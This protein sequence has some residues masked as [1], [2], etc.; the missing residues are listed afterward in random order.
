MRGTIALDKANSGQVNSKELRN[1]E[2]ASEKVFGEKHKQ[3]KHYE[4]RGLERGTVMEM[5]VKRVSR[6]QQ[7]YG[8][9]PFSFQLWTSPP[10]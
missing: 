4:R 2:I 3:G 10:W 5:G 7:G 1:K 9:S 8:C 6:C